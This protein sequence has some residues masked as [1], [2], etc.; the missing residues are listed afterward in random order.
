M[1]D[2][3]K[4]LLE[5]TEEE[6]DEKLDNP[7]EPAADDTSSPELKVEGAE[8]EGAEEIEDA[9]DAPVS[10]DESAE[11]A[12]DETTVEET[13]VTD[14]QPCEH[15][16]EAA[17]E[18]EVQAEEATASDP[19]YDEPETKE[20]ETPIVEEDGAFETSIKTFTQDDVDKLVGDTRVKTRE[21]TFRYIY[22]RYGVKSEE[23]LDSLVANAQRYDTQKDMYD[24]DKKSWE[25]E[26]SEND[27]RLSEM[28]EQIALMQSG[29]DPERYEDAKLILKGKGLEVSLEN[30]NAEMETHPEWKKAEAPAPAPEEPKPTMR[31][32]ALGNEQK[33][34]PELSEEEQAQKLFK[35]KW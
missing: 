11:P 1:E 33:P 29:I 25:A 10:A 30:I 34:A 7:T 8:L 23:E 32:K 14:E 17:C 2:K 9:V 20:P 28:S 15:E 27:K 22:D 19:V 4:E 18:P 3:L 35:L 6:Q 16:P 5:G 26:K 12:T 31:I 21:K 24:A 13:V